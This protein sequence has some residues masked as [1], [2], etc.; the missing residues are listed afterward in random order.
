VLGRPGNG[1]VSYLVRMELR[2][3]GRDRSGSCR[4]QTPQV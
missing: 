4:S 1:S 3:R 2:T